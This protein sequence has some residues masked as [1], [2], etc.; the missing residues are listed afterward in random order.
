VGVAAGVEVIVSVPV[1]EV[2]GA[3][4]LVGVNMG[5]LVGAGSVG[6]EVGLRVGVAVGLGG[7]ITIFAGF[8]RIIKFVLSSSVVAELARVLELKLIV[9]PKGAADKTLKE[10]EATFCPVPEIEAPVA[11]PA[12]P[13]TF[14]G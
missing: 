8:L 12:E 4:V 1:G 9:V 6:V 5:V 7:A 2:V 13:V 11:T 10:R 3:G 14:P